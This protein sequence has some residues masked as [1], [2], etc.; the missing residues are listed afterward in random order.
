[1]VALTQHAAVPAEHN[2]GIVRWSYATLAEMVAATGM[3]AGHIN[4]VAYVAETQKYYV[5]RNYDPVT[6]Q[7]LSGS[8]TLVSAQ[9]DPVT[10][11]ITFTFADGSEVL[12]NQVGFPTFKDSDFTIENAGTGDAVYLQVEAGIASGG[13]EIPS[14][15][16]QRINSVVA[17]DVAYSWKIG[18][19][20]RY[21]NKIWVS[22]ADQTPGA[23]ATAS[24]DELSND[25]LLNYINDQIAALTS[26]MNSSIASEIS[27][28]LY[29]TGVAPTVNDD[30]TLG[31]AVNSRWY[32]IT[33]GQEYI[34]LD[35]T[36]AAADWRTVAAALPNW[37]FANQGNNYGTTPQATAL[38]SQAFGNA[39]SAAGIDSVAV[40]S[41]SVVG[42][43]ATAGIA[44]GSGAT[45]Q[46]SASIA[47]GFSANNT[48]SSSIAV[49]NNASAPGASSVAL[50]DTALA[51]DAD[52]ISVGRTAQSTKAGIAIGQGASAG[53]TGA[54][55]ASRVAIGAGA[56]AG[57]GIGSVSNVAIGYNAIATAQ[58]G[59]GSVV[60]G[61]NS[62]ADSNNEDSV[63]VG[64]A[65]AVSGTGG[66]QCVYVG[67]AI[68]TATGQER[69]VLVGHSINTSGD[70]GVAVGYG[71][72]CRSTSVA[73]GRDAATTTSGTVTIGYTASTG[74]NLRSIAIGMSANVTGTA[75]YSVAI[76]YAAYAAGLNAVSLGYQANI[77]AAANNA[78]AI[79][80]QSDVNFGHGTA[81]GRASVAD[82]GYG[83]AL[84][85]Y[86]DVD[87][88]DGAVKVGGITQNA[89]G[90]VQTTKG[91]SGC[92]IMQ[93]T[94][95][96]TDATPKVFS[97]PIQTGRL[98]YGDLF[99][100]AKDT[101][102]G[103]VWSQ[104][105]TFCAK[106]NAGTAALVG[107][108][109]KTAA[110]NDAGLAALVA[111]VSVSGANFTVTLTGIAATNIDWAGHMHLQQSGV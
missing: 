2:H 9:Y 23:F 16:Y 110:L 82:I 87:T 69:S 39:A 54:A 47:I 91:A 59:T 21:D 10:F 57:S 34:C 43:A 60:V 80:Y 84:G 75:S 78:V 96:T 30:E 106:N 88:W 24:W 103:A 41:T 63:V 22:R 27:S 89:A 38:N 61:A 29:V 93:L 86:A 1:M 3:A 105:I 55:A 20:C 19:L 14:R 35:P 98:F 58:I 62:S 85:P 92:M 40:G 99:I 97:F 36:E 42:G 73:V 74:N 31:Y 107:T 53:G 12:S 94:D 72:Y 81:L 4:T 102:T 71:S 49:G 13:L 66:G 48:G 28:N 111:D 95:A 101:G 15:N 6:W 32:N 18:D 50:G 67:G 25:G 100:T 77:A 7:S 45:A 26:L 76:G 52:S 79:G 65:I 33:T 56:N 51:T 8:S 83:T 90:T 68:T 17:Y 46:G 44:V 70:D 64:S 5:L 109:Q 37:L 108:P 11:V 104:K